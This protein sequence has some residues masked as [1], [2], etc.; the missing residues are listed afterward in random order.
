MNA[1]TKHYQE[2][3]DGRGFYFTRLDDGQAM[4]MTSLKIVKTI[5][6]KVIWQDESGQTTDA[7]HG[8]AWDA[9]RQPARAKRAAQLAANQKMAELRRYYMVNDRRWEVVKAEER[10]AEKAKRDAQ[11][12]AAK[13]LRE[14]GPDLLAACKAGLEQL[15]L[16]TM[17][18]PRDQ[19]EDA[20]AAIAEMRAAIA[21]A[22]VAPAETK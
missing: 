16:F 1:I 6:P 10:K 12:A 15:E 3:R 2:G 11:I 5:I 18:I 21:K 22:E 9:E 8:S 13:R 14:A 4:D 20:H 7:W 19:D 17:S